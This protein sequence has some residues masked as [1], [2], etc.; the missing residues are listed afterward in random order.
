MQP[1]RYLNT[2]TRSGVKYDAG[3]RKHFNSIYNRMALGLAVTAVTAFFVAGSPYL[4]QMIFGT[5]LK[6]VVM[7]AP[8]AVVWFGF[9]PARMSS[10]KLQAAFLA[11]SVLYGI[12]FSVIFLAFS[13]ESIAR[14]FFVTSGMFAGISVFG[15]VT[16]KDLSAW[17][18][19]LVMGIM[20][21]FLVSVLG[22][23]FQYSSM[24][25]TLID[26]GAVALFSGLTAFETQ[27]AKMLYSANYGTEANSRMAWSSALTLY[28]SFIAIFI[29]M[30]QLMNQR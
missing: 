3:L 2:Q 27:K 18:T 10:A 13:G 17:G 20:G 26:L 5:P 25:H 24:M 23:F 1:E 7:F 4:L 14:A 19:F 11:I 6:F 30:L 29:H 8:I 12:S 28:I 16:K 9:N 21:L 22:V 15:Y